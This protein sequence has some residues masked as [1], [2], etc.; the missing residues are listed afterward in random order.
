[1]LGIIFLWKR[2]QNV[3][4]WKRNSRVFNRLKREFNSI[5]IGI[6]FY[7]LKRIEENVNLSSEKDM[8]FSLNQGK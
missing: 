7:I 5:L 4:A 8:S 6:N 2:Y 3:I 1:M